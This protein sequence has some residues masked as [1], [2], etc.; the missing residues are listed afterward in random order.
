[1]KPLADAHTVTQGKLHTVHDLKA[2]WAS[3]CLAPVILNLGTRCRSVVNFTP[4]S[5]YPQEI[6]PV[7]TKQEVVLSFRRIKKILL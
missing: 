1:M 3:E 7:P 6:T 4:P 2:Y 5:F